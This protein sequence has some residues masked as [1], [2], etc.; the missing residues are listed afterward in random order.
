MMQIKYDCFGREPLYLTRNDEV[1]EYKD[2]RT[3]RREKRKQ[4]RK[5]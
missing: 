1:K 5:K 3:L 4:K 2:G